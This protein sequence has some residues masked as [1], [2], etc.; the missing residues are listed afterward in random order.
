MRI[1]R[2]LPR[3]VPGA[4]GTAGEAGAILLIGILAACA[5][6][7]YLFALG[8]AQLAEVFSLFGGVRTVAVVDY[9]E[10]GAWPSPLPSLADSP[11]D[12]PAAAGVRTSGRF[13]ADSSLAHDGRLTVKLV[14]DAHPE[15]AARRLDFRLATV[16][17]VH[18]SQLLWVCGS[19]EPPD[20]FVVHGV[21]SSN[22]PAAYLPHL[23]REEVPR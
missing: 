18:S 19:R 9:A 16:P 20:G 1:A 7:Y 23:C 12:E 3:L 21:D 10:Q 14:S 13:V 2:T 15:V 17:G 4:G 8:K 22:V 6:H 5:T 11:T